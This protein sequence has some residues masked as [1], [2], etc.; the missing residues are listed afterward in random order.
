MPLFL[1]CSPFSV[2]LLPWHPACA[3]WL[4]ALAVACSSSI[5][6]PWLRHTLG[7][8][9][10]LA[11]LCSGWPAPCQRC[12]SAASSGHG[13]PSGGD[14]SH[15]GCVRPGGSDVGHSSCGRTGAVCATATAAYPAARVSASLC[16]GQHRFVSSLGPT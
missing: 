13:C 16:T 11:A 4:C 2:L 6:M 12:T 14:M 3:W 7:W 1:C 15:G 5:A 10:L 8:P 9:H